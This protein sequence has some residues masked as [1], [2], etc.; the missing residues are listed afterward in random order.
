MGAGTWFPPTNYA[1]LG[2]ISSPRLGYKN[3]LQF[4]YALFQNA[5][6]EQ[7]PAHPLWYTPR[8][9]VADRADRQDVEVI[10]MTAKKSV[11]APEASKHLLTCATQAPR[12]SS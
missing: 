11:V 7:D 12:R 6:V 5:I 8:R 2:S 3:L 10:V 9:G 4:H 1:D